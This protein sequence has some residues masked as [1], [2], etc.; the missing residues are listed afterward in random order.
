VES[1]RRSSN[2]PLEFGYSRQIASGGAKHQFGPY[3]MCNKKMLKEYKDVVVWT[4][5]DLRGIP[6]HLTQHQIEFDTNIHA[7]HQ[8]QYRMN[9][10]YDVV[11]KQDLD[12]LLAIGFITPMEK[13]TWLYPIV[14]VLKK[15]MKL[16]ICM[17]F[18]KLNIV[19]KKD[20]Y[21]LPIMEEVLD[22]VAGHEVYSFLDGFSSYHHI[23]ITPKDRYK[24]AFI[25]DWGTFVWIVMLSGLKNVPPTYQ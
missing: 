7:S 10:N 11:V 25:I 9:S 22:M 18:Q 1:I 14:V 15:N 2:S 8:A 21:H 17:N 16:Q 5:K 20:P 6:P 13:A 23:T 19:T 24:I 12:T 4:Y 3:S